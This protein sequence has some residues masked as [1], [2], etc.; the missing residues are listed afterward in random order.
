MHGRRGDDEAALGAHVD[1]G[2]G[3]LRVAD[4]E[5][6]GVLEI[7]VLPAAAGSGAPGFGIA[8]ELV[9]GDPPAPCRGSGD[10]ALFVEVDDQELKA[11]AERGGAGQ[12]AHAVVVAVLAVGPVPALM[13][14]FGNAVLEFAPFAE[15][16]LFPA[17][18]RYDGKT[19]GAV[20]VGPLPRAC[21]FFWQFRC[22]RPRAPCRNQFMHFVVDGDRKVAASRSPRRSAGARHRGVGAAGLR[23]RH[24]GSNRSRR[25]VKLASTA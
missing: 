10:G 8:A 20:A 1:A 4:M 19:E 16:H 17:G 7:D 11:A 23:R 2:D 22:H 18:R 9:L 24:L 13:D 21:K 14:G 15:R 6:V 25:F 5:M 3:L 12:E